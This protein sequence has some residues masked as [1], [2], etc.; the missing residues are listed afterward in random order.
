MRA[1]RVKTPGWSGWVMVPLRLFLV[2][3]PKSSYVRKKNL[4]E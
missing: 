3:V 2:Q 4:I 1:K